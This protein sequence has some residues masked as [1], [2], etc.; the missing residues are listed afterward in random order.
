V[1]ALTLTKV[2]THLRI[3]GT[4]DDA[5]LTTHITRVVRVA[6]RILGRRYSASSVTEKHPG[7]GTAVMLRAWPVVAVTAVTEEGRTLTAGTGYVVDE[8][9]GIVY[10][11]P[12]GDRFAGGPVAVSVTFTAG[13]VPDDGAELGLLEL[14]RE[15]WDTQRGGRLPRQAS[16]DEWV[17]SEDLRRRVRQLLRADMGPEAG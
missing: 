1:G 9:A 16:E 6:E 4:Q 8:T 14:T 2:K 11:A 12:D 3:E 15:L 7:G 10:R 17:A 5:D 13:A